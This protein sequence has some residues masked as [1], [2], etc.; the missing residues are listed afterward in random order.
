MKYCALNHLTGSS[1]LFEKLS[2]LADYLYDLDPDIDDI[3]V[4]KLKEIKAE[5]VSRYVII[6]N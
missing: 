5:K 3:T 2:D 4:F 1:N 6:D